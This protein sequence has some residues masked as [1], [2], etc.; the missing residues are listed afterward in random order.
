MLPSVWERR[1]FLT[2]VFS[3]SFRLIAPH[4][5]SSVHRPSNDLGASVYR[6]KGTRKRKKR[7]KLFYRS[8]FGKRRIVSATL[9]D[10][11]APCAAAYVHDFYLRCSRQI[12]E[13]KALFFFFLLLLG[14]DHF[15]VFNVQF[16][17]VQ[18]GKNFVSKGV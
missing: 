6:I 3:L 13:R 1:L 11:L 5:F 12:R 9:L 15:S 16:F 17:G 14:G 4:S 7:K 18:K 2:S 10:C 8:P